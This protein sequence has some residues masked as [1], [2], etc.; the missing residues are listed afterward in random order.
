MNSLLSII[1]HVHR[2]A[3]DGVRLCPYKTPSVVAVVSTQLLRTL[4]ALQTRHESCVSR[5]SSHSD[6]VLVRCWTLPELRQRH[7][8]DT[9]QVVD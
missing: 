2:I 1:E 6:R 7:T 3:R 5:N 8:V 4:E 9:N